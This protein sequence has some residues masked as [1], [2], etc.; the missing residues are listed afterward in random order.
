MNNNPK[1]MTG[2]SSEGKPIHYSV[3][4]IIKQE[5][6]NMYLLLDRKKIPFGMACSAGHIDEGELPEEAL[7]REVKEETGLTVVEY[8]LIFREEILWNECRRGIKGHDV[9]VYEC[10]VE[11]DIE[12]SLE[13]TKS[14]GWYSPEKMALLKLEP[15]WEYIFGKLK[16]IPYKFKKV[17][18]CGSIKFFK[19]MEEIKIKLETLGYKV[20]IPQLSLE[21]PP[22]YGGG[23]NVYFGGVIEKNGGINSFPIGHEI[24]D[25][26]EEAIRG[27]LEKISWSDVI[28]VVNPQKNNL[29]GYVG[30]NTLIEMGYA[31]MINK[32]IYVLNS[33][34]NEISYIH[35]IRGMKPIIIDGD[36]EEYFT[37]IN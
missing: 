29:E 7:I 13:E 8:K 32:P 20:K 14:I 9:F 31:F 11:G 24:W 6:E 27:H 15:V 26:K 23:N 36:I 16:I 17:T 19:E 5:K 35:E 12:R 33:I 2:L 28:L 18:I 37:K 10:K 30:G 21:A 4:A 34:S 3:G 22:E 1:P 25:L